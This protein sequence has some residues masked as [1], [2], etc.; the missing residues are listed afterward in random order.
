MTAKELAAALG[1]PL[2]RIAQWRRRGMPA[3]GVHKS[4]GPGRPSLRFDLEACR[5]WLLKTGRTA[6]V[7]R[8]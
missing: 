7:G 6:E 5:A 3:T 1:V 8:G 4:G 2:W